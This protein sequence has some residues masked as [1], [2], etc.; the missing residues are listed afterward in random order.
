MLI[1]I[2][3]VNADWQRIHLAVMLKQLFLEPLPANFTLR[4]S[5]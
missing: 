5:E 1:K 4:A 3:E 2:K